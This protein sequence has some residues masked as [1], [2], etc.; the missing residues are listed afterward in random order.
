MTRQDDDKFAQLERVLADAHRSRSEPALGPELAQ[1]V[2]RD[3][4]GLSDRRRSSRPESGWI[5]SVVW[6]SAMATAGL[7]AFLVVAAVWYT[8]S[9]RGEQPALLAE[10]FD[11]DSAFGE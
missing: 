9:E 7:A 4:H 8:A 5:E 3:I 11:E 2:M 10:E 6:R 1:A